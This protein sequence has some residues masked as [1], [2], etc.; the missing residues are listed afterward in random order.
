MIVYYAFLIHL[1]RSSAWIIGA[2]AKTILFQKRVFD[3][4]PNAF[5]IFMIKIHGWSPCQERKN[6]IGSSIHGLF[7]RSVYFGPRFFQEH[8]PKT[9]TTRSSEN[10]LICYGIAR[11]IIVDYNCFKFSIYVEVHCVEPDFFV[12]VLSFK[13]FTNSLRI[14]SY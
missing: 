4:P 14:L 6:R 3:F 5:N 1:K 10:W 12:N 9:I 13:Y 2:C 11:E 7:V 8:N